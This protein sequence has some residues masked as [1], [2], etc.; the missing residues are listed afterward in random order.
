MNFNFTLDAVSIILLAI[1]FMGFIF[2]FA[3]FKLFKNFIKKEK[4]RN[5]AFTRS[6]MDAYKETDISEEFIKD[7]INDKDYQEKVNE[8][9]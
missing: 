9:N 8:G 3:D 5:I 1:L 4:D 6:Q 2:L 7:F